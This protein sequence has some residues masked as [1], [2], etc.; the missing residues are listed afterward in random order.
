MPSCGMSR[1]DAQRAALNV[2]D[3]AVLSGR[4]AEVLVAP[5]AL[6]VRW[7]RIGHHDQYVSHGRAGRP[8]SS[9]A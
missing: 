9:D 4:R 8:L 1:D 3:D 7:P 6:G 5:Q 2:E